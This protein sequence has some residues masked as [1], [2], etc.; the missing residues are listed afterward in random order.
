MRASSDEFLALEEDG[1]KYQLINGVVVMSPSPG[2]PHQALFALVIQQLLNHLERA[3]GGT[4]LPECDVRFDGATVYQ[5]DIAYFLPGRQSVAS[6]GN[7]VIPDFVIEIVSPSS[8]RM[9]WQTKRADYE[10]F[11]VREYWIVTP[12]P[13]KVEGFRLRNGK[14]EPAPS[15]ADQVASDVI[16]GFVLDLV[17]VRKAM[18]RR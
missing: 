5:P 10:R 16:T 2:K 3:S 17:A 9:D 4:V 13:V 14:Y 18:N 11:G 12:E 7:S 6:P 8:A 15:N 1:F